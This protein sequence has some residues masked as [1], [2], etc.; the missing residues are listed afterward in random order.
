MGHGLFSDARAAKRDPCPRVIYE[1]RSKN[2]ILPSFSHCM[3]PVCARDLAV[4]WCMAETPWS[5][6]TALDRDAAAV[7]SHMDSESQFDRHALPFRDDD[8]HA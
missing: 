1:H 8:F 5:L 7:A 3:R 6:F 2:N 4:S